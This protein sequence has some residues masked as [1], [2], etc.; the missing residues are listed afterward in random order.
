ML[1]CNIWAGKSVLL[2]H[3]IDLYDRFVRIIMGGW[4]GWGMGVGGWGWD[5]RWRGFLGMMI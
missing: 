3:I 5:K 4:K 2:F 1:D